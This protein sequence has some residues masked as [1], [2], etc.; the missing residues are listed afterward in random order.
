MKERG[1]AGSKAVTL[2]ARVGLSLGQK[3]EREGRATA[4]AGQVGENMTESS[5]ATLSVFRTTKFE[6]GELRGEEGRRKVPNLKVRVIC[7]SDKKEK[8]NGWG[9]GE[10]KK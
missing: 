10:K 1:E 3:L 4:A 6:R 8:E 9:S 5:K 2:L 7:N